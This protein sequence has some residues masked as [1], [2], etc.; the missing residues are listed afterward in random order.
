MEHSEEFGKQNTAESFEEEFARKTEELERKRQE[1]YKKR[2]ERLHRHRDEEHLAVYKARTAAQ[3]VAPPV[4]RPRGEGIIKRTVR[5]IRGLRETRRGMAGKE[6]YT[7]E[8]RRAAY[9][10]VLRDAW[11]PVCDAAEDAVDTA[12]DFLSRFA[13]DLWLCLLFIADMFI[14]AWYY[15]GSIALFLWDLIWDFRLWLEKRKRTLFSIFVA[16]VSTVALGAVIIS[17][18]TAYEYS[19]HGRKLGITKTEEAVYET[20]EA[21]GDKLSEASGAN[22]SLDVE[23]DI[24]FN[25]IYGFNLEIDSR[26]DILTVLTYMKDLQVQAYAILIDGQ[27]KVILEDENTAKR[28]LN[29]IKNDFTPPSEGVE[30]TSIDF[31]EDVEIQ[32]VD[33]LLG[34]IWNAG[35]AKSYIEVG[36]TNVPA[37]YVSNPMLTV[38]T[39]ELYTYTEDIEYGTQY[40][41]NSNMYLDEKELKSPGVVGKNQIVAEVRRVNG[42]EIDSQMV[43]VTQVVDPVDEVYYIGTKSLPVRSGSGTF[44]APLTS[45]TLSSTFGMR[46]GRMHKGVDLA[47]ST[48]TKIHAA[49]GGTVTYSGWMGSY[50][51]LVIIDHGGLYETYYA[52]CSKLLVSVGD[53]VYQDQ[54]IAE[55]GS[56]GNSTG[57]HCH[58][59]VRYKGEPQNPLDYI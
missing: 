41:K 39:T 1:Y 54:V 8:R 2:G 12:W 4:R 27:Q 9:A 44:L 23:R 32:E 18:M 55:V 48:G 13:S 11:Q 10:E 52:H 46:W 47:A 17:S 6:W 21:L 26:E 16:G 45:Y 36:A 3:S 20:I 22:V 5:L 50:G 53:A 56:T 25:K 37:E 28:I 15:L 19:Y 42:E 59:E 58:F 40:V 57:P 49:D 7:A 51:Y 30:Y 29:S 24:G 38:A 35:D 34:D 43:S 33:A 14:A 31:L